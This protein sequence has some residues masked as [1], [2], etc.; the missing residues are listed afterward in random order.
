MLRYLSGSTENLHSVHF[1]NVVDLI[2]E[3]PWPAPRRGEEDDVDG[4][5]EVRDDLEK[6]PDNEL[7][8]V[9]DAVDPRVAPRPADLFGV[10]VD[11]DDALAGHGELDGVSPD[12]AE[13][14]DDEVAATPLGYVASNALWR[15]RVPRL[16]VHEDA[17]VI[18]LPEEVPPAPI[19]A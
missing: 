3:V 5:S 1:T 4:P 8:A 9:L 13:A 19:F 14:V 15:H 10:D 16:L 12:A 6:V 18:A 7:D 2:G 11:G 17:L